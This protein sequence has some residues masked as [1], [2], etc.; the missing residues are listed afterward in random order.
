MIKITFSMIKRM[1]SRKTSYTRKGLISGL[2]AVGETVAF[3]TYEHEGKQ[4]ESMIAYLEK[5]FENRE[6]AIAW[7]KKIEEALRWIPQNGKIGYRVEIANN[8]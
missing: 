5:E 1:Q 3:H 8:S 2:L 7:R 4:R 6:D